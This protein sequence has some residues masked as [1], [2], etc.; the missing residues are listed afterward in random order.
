MATVEQSQKMVPLITCE[1][2]LCQHVCDLVL[3][4]DVFD[5]DFGVQIDSIKQPIECNSVSPGNMSHCRTHTTKPLDA[6]TGRLR[7]QNQYSPS[8]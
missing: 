2:T 7:E 5:L 1:I 8:H 3:G 6:R 4:V